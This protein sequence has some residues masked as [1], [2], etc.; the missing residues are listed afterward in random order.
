MA[1]YKQGYKRKN[2]NQKWVNYSIYG[3]IGAAVI[4]ILVL[5]GNAILNPALQYEDFADVTIDTMDEI[6]VQEEDSY[7]VYYYGE[8]CG[9]CKTIKKQVLEF[10]D[11]NDNNIKVY[12]IESAEDKDP[13]VI[14]H[15][16]TSVPMTGTPSMVTVK[17]GVV[18]DINA[19]PDL[20][21]DLI[22]QVN[23]GTYGHLN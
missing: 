3:L 15:P 13:T 4:A 1:E 5:I 21:L 2:N 6:T 23:E 17:N 9:Y 11:E 20:I 10:A 16:T 8:D 22:E 18:V 19:G 12:L 14:V 7:L